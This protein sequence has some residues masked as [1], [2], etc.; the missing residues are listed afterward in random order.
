[1]GFERSI[2]DYL[3]EPRFDNFM[4]KR[5]AGTDNVEKA[6][7]IIEK[8]VKG[9]KKKRILLARTSINKQERRF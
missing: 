3:N 2:D 4:T 9:S 1:M 5:I 8:K 6:I 7:E